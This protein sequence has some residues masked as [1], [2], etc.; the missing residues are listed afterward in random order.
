MQT[1]IPAGG[2]KI[3]SPADNIC[4]SLDQ[5]EPK[6]TLGLLLIICGYPF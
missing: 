4:K 5:I 3:V 6:K 1:K 2:N